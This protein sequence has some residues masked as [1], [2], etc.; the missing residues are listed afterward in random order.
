MERQGESERIQGCSTYPG[1][2][3][4]RIP[5]ELETSCSPK[6]RGLRSGP[7][8]RAH[9]AAARRSQR[10]GSHDSAGTRSRL[11][12]HDCSALHC[13]IRTILIEFLSNASVRSSLIEFLSLGLFEVMITIRQVKAARALLAWSQEDLARQAGLSYPTIAR[14]EAV[15][16]T[17]GGRH[18]TVAAIQRALESAGV[19]FTNGGQPGVRMRAR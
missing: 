2:R 11:L 17:L 12:E 19:E 14:I 5:I 9:Q 8:G 1:K 13:S 16:G 6:S 3:P 15:D 7:A 18:M 4:Q 10:V